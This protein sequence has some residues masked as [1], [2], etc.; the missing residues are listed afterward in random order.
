MLMRRDGHPAP[1]VAMY[2]CNAP[3][4][5]HP[6]PEEHRFLAVGRVAAKLADTLHAYECKLSRI[7]WTMPGITLS[8][9]PVYEWPVEHLDLQCP[10][11]P[12][13]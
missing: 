4:D 8:L 2:M 10:V 5:R 13:C 9:L 7:V 11:L 1:S 6:L 3:D 12:L